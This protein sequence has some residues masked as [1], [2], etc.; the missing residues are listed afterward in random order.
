MYFVFDCVRDEKVFTD[1]S[2][3][4]RK[5]ILKKGYWIQFFILWAARLGMIVV[6]CLILAPLDLFWVVFSI[7]FSLMAVLGIYET[8]HRD[9]KAGRQ[10]LEELIPG[11]E[12]QVVYF[13]DDAYVICTSVCKLE[14]RYITISQVLEDQNYFVLVERGGKNQRNRKKVNILDK[15]GLRV[16][17]IDDFRSF[18]AWKIGSPVEFV[19]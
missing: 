19:E 8:V 9:Q 2:R 7:V 1:L 14:Y 11:T 15:R 6:S 18:I 16:G 12:R 3:I 17:T 4:G 5:S 13:Y 10:I